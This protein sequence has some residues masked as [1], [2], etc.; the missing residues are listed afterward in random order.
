MKDKNVNEH[1][2]D[3]RAGE[4]CQSQSS[5]KWNEA[6]KT[7]GDFNGGGEVSEPLAKSDIVEDMYPVRRCAGRDFVESGQ[8]EY[9]RETDANRNTG[10]C[11]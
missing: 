1:G 11:I 10:G 6:Q 2:A 9:E 8:Y 7:A 5:S 3:H 4:H